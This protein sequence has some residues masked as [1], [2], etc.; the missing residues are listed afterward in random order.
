MT[1]G[2]YY[3]SLKNAVWLAQFL[4]KRS[5]VNSNAEVWIINLLFSRNGMVEMFVLACIVASVPN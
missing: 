5:S 2:R 1:S 4:L 3:N